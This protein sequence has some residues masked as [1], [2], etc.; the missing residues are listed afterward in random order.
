VIVVSGAQQA[1]DL[2]A[3]VLLDAGDVAAVEDPGYRGTRAALSA[4]GAALAPVPLDAEGLDVAA[5]RTLAPRARVV[6]VT[7]SHQFPLGVTMSASRRLAL[8]EWARVTEGWIVED[9]F[10][11]EYRFRGR[12]LPSLQGMDDA[13]RVLYVGT[14]S[15]TLFPALRLGY[16]IVPSE[17]V[18]VFMRARAVVDRHPPTLEQAVLAEFIAEGHLA[19]HVRRMRALYAERQELLLT[20]VAS[21]LGEFLEGERM[22]AGMHLVAWMRPLPSRPSQPVDQ[23]LARAALNE[24]V[25]AVALT[26]LATN[27]PC[28]P[29]LLLGF[30]AH[31]DMSMRRGVAQLRIAANIVAAPLASRKSR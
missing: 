7:P 2:I 1:F 24:G 21:E 15:K 10:D 14:F 20:L 30:A 27:A 5:L 22:E 4:A 29:A 13:R 11:S 3:R 31:D 28:R 23:R 17:L 18:D 19:R 16:L 25:A 8:L 6:C 9:D 26:S 12:P